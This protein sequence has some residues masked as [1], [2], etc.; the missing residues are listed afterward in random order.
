MA[1]FTWGNSGFNSSNCVNKLSEVGKANGKFHVVY[2][3]TSIDIDDND[4]YTL[5]VMNEGDDDTKFE[6]VLETVFSML[7][8]ENGNDLEMDRISELAE[9]VSHLLNGEYM[10]DAEYED[11]VKADMEVIRSFYRMFDVKET[12]KN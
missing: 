12:E 10:E 11:F 8:L 5:T 4:V 1:S 9:T 3:E 2:G 6:S 7:Y